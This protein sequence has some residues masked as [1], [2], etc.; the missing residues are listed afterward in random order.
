MDF[1][2]AGLRYPD[3]SWGNILANAEAGVSSGNW[4]WPTFPGLFLMVTVL[5]L[6]FLGDGLADALDVRTTM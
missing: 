2:G 5:A 1:L 3:V 6:N 4:W